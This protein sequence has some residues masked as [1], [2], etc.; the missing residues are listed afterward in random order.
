MHSTRERILAHL[1]REPAASVDVLSHALELAPMTIRQQLA[2]MTSDGLIEAESE[3]RPTGRPAHVYS[4]TSKGDERFPK[5]YDRLAAILLEE[6]TVLEPGDLEGLSPAGRRAMLFQR[7]AV[8]AAAPHRADLERLSGRERAE[9]ATAILQ[10]ESGFTELEVTNAGV[11]IREYNCVYQR[12]A[13]GHNDVCAFHTEYVS[14]LV[15]TSVVLDGCQCEGANA[16]RFVV[17]L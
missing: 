16:C 11:E 17:A 14:Q 12:V 8:R 13:E 6:I 2:K 7:I 15:G 10:S 5:A 4:L 1:K 3:R 9:A